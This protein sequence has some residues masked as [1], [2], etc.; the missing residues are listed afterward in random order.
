MMNGD[1][2]V[3]VMQ[4]DEG[5]FGIIGNVGSPPEIPVLLTMFIV[6][7]CF[8]VPGHDG[9][10]VKTPEFYGIFEDGSHVPVY[11]LF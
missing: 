10:I 3:S 9:I 4:I 8:T 6:R 2:F 5:T 1:E 7:V 11:P